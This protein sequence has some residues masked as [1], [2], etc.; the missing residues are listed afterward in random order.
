MCLKLGMYPNTEARDS[1]MKFILDA[2]AYIINYSRKMSR[3]SKACQTRKYVL[4]TWYV[5]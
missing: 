2:D 5:P 1:N 3:V 4:E